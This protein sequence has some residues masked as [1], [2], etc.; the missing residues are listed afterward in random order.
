MM[1]KVTVYVFATGTN[2]SRKIARKLYEDIA[3]RVLPVSNFPAHRTIREFRALHLSEFTELFVEV[4][5]LAREISLAKP[6]ARA[7]EDPRGGRTGQ[8]RMG[9]VVQTPSSA[10]AHWLHPDGRG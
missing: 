7:L 5:R 6:P 4:Q 9:H 3:F 1:V 8:P 10:A 2:R